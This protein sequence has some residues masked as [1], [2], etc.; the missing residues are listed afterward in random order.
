MSDAWRC[1]GIGRPKRE[2]KRAKAWAV[3]ARSPRGTPATAG[4]AAAIARTDSADQVIVPLILSA[5]L[6][7][8]RNQATPSSPRIKD[9][10]KLAAANSRK[11]A[12]RCGQTHAHYR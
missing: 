3:Q 10:V 12:L 4:F 6:E 7:S 8:S 1:G 9:F 11:Q 5:D 2:S